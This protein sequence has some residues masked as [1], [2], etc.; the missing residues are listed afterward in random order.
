MNPFRIEGHRLAEMLA[1]ENLTEREE[2]V[3]RLLT[4]GLGNKEIATRLDVLVNTVKTHLKNVFR[5]LG[6]KSRLEAMKIALSS[7]SFAKSKTTLS[8]EA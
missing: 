6:V 1:M 3:L 5:K 2:K 4:Q 7:N 8:G